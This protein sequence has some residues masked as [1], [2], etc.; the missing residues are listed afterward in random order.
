MSEV[1]GY[2]HLINKNTDINKYYLL[3]DWRAMTELWAAKV[4]TLVKKNH[5]CRKLATLTT[6][7]PPT[8]FTALA[9]K[10][11][12]GDMW[13]LTPDTWQVGEVNLLSKFQLPSLH[14]S[15]LKV[16]WRYFHKV[17]LTEWLNEWMTKVFVE[18]PQLHR[19]C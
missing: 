14:T 18:Q 6:D 16:F 15:V 13:H 8:N 12:K 7:P 11:K 3:H 17:W 1:Q 10:K 4:T 5:Q 19:V 2:Y 9:K